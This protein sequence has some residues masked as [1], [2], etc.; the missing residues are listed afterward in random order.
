V[1]RTYLCGDGYISLRSRAPGISKLGEVASY[2]SGAEARLSPMAVRMQSLIF[3]IA[4]QK[5][6]R[7]GRVSGY[8]TSSL[9]SPCAITIDPV[10]PENH[11]RSQP[12]C[13]NG[14]RYTQVRIDQAFSALIGRFAAV[15]D[16]HFTILN[17]GPWLRRD[18][19]G[20]CHHRGAT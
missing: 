6:Q 4:M 2:T 8:H 14:T 5:A 12:Y 13:A 17:A 20:P 1:T 19:S 9:R 11:R 10:T 3:V 16:Y 15:N 18:A 7:H